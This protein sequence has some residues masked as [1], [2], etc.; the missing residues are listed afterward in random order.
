M[1]SVEQLWYNMGA[2]SFGYH[3]V[4]QRLHL[5]V[6]DAVDAKLRD[7]DTKARE[8]YLMN[9]LRTR[10]KEKGMDLE[11]VSALV[12]KKP[13][14]TVDLASIIYPLKLQN[15]ELAFSALSCLCR[16]R[17][18][19]PHNFQSNMHSLIQMFATEDV[20]ELKAAVEHNLSKLAAV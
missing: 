6:K 15:R 18:V 1:P 14:I 19:S 11:M 17:A 10:T 2:L 16:H 8:E 3:V 12:E 7:F 13:H 9:E 20:Q 4:N 5:F